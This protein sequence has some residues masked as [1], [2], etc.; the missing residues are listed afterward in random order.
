MRAAALC[1]GTTDSIFVRIDE[2]HAQRLGTAVIYLNRRGVIAAVEIAIGEVIIVVILRPHLFGELLD[3]SPLNQS[4]AME[5]LPSW[6]A[7]FVSLHRP[8]ALD[9]LDD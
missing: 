1:C 4:G 6:L 2:L 3:S 5:I 9:D 7:A 8:V